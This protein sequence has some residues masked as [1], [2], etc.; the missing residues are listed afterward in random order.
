MMKSGGHFISFFS[1]MYLLPATFELV[2][3]GMA[4]IDIELVYKITL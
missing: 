2:V 4:V 3:C 1:R